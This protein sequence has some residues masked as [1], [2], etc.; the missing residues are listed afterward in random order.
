MGAN[1]VAVY[2]YRLGRFAFRNRWWMLGAWVGMLVAAG[3]AAQTLSGQSTSSFSVPG[4][5][6]Q[7]ALDLMEV[8]AIV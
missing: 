2:L 1:L 5:P 3:V 4:T 8:S 6:A 7:E